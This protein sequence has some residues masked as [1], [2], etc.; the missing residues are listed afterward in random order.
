MLDR[1]KRRLPDAG[2]DAL[3]NDLL[4]DAGAMIQAYTGQNAVPD[5]LEGAQLEI[6]VML[7]N[8]MGMEGEA[9]HAEGSVS[10][11]ADSLPEYLRR[12]LNPFRLVKAVR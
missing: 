1:L 12:Q 11:S 5:V 9:S 3:L 7:F 2:N 6:A 4:A 10:R 8:R